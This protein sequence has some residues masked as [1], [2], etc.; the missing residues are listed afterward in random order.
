MITGDF[1]K[2][3]KIT[4]SVARLA[5]SGFRRVSTDGSVAISDVLEEQYAS[6]SGPNRDP[7]APLAS[8]E[9][10]HL[11]DT[12]HMRST[13]LSTPVKGVSVRI[14][15]PGKFHQKG[16]KNRDGSRRM[17]ARPIVPES[18]SLPER[19]SDPLKRSARSVIWEEF[20][21]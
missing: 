9:P 20:D 2:L 18:S 1:D 19:W 14:P 8:G 13:S 4:E 10:S 21:G 11:T 16:T 7:W 5:S 3:Q 17:P 12:G 15:F 6:G